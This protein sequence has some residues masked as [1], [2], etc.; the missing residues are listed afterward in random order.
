MF[1]C[2]HLGVQSF[3]V[4]TS[5]DYN[6]HGVSDYGIRRMVMDLVIE[7]SVPTNMEPN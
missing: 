3:R 5:D 4:S 1:A 7:F 6:S 2:F